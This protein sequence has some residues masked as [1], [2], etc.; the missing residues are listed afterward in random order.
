MGF[1]CPKCK[2]DFYYDK[3]AFEKH[4]D[5]CAGLFTGEPLKTIKGE[6]GS[7]NTMNDPFS[8]KIKMQ[9]SLDEIDI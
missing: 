7:S 1:K 9:I 4:Y 8:K 5:Q 6:G 3:F 2:Q